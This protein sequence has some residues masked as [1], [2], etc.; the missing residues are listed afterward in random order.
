MFTNIVR[1]RAYVMKFDDID[2]GENIEGQVLLIIFISIK[3][4]FRMRNESKVLTCDSNAFY[5]KVLN[6]TEFTLV[7]LLYYS[8]RFRRKCRKIL[9]YL[10]KT[11]NYFF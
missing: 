10:K 3:Y 7:G 11:W 2:T 9:I 4:K 1:H 5:L 6:I 8:V